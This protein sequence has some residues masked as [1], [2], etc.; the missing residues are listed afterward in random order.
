[1]QERLLPISEENGV[2]HRRPHETRARA[3]PALVPHGVGV[4]EAELV[5]GL[6]FWTH[7]LE[8]AALGPL[9]PTPASLR[10]RTPL[11]PPP[12]LPPGA[13]RLDAGGLSLLLT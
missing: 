4:D 10:A 5:A 9:R 12:S 6:L 2:L 11:R 13:P 3:P 8:S 7:G 1:M